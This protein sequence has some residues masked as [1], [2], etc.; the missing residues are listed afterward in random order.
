[1]DTSTKDRLTAA[2]TP[3]MVLVVSYALTP[4]LIL[5]LPPMLYYIYR[6]IS[7]S[8]SKDTTLKFFDLVFSIFLIALGVGAIIGALLIVARDG[9]FTIPLVSSGLLKTIFS[10]SAAF[11][12]VGSSI[13]LSIKSFKEQPYTPKLSMG[14]FEALRGKRVSSV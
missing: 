3:V 7:F 12:L 2:A 5:L 13:M 8:L 4:W 6:K 11:Y 14:I 1:M 10:I 9:E